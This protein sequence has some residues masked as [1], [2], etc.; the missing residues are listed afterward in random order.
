MKIG[1][2]HFRNDHSNHSLVSVTSCHLVTNG[3][4]ALCAH[5]DFNLLDHPGINL[6]ATLDLV[7][8]ALTICIKLSESPF[9]GADDFKDLVTDRTRIDFDVVVDCC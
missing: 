4:F 2:I 6:V 1:H 3:Q 9:E 5:K 7:K 8:A